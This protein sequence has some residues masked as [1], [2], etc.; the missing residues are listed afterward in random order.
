M[1]SAYIWKIGVSIIIRNIGNKAYWNFYIFYKNLETSKVSRDNN[2]FFFN[3]NKF[4]YIINDYS[5]FNSPYMCRTYS[6]IIL[7]ACETRSQCL[8]RST[9]SA[10]EAI[11]LALHSVLHALYRRSTARRTRM[12]NTIWNI[13]SVCFSRSA[14]SATEAISFAL[15][16]VS[17][18]FKR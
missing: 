2:N 4:Y 18:A 11:S 12:L 17:H 16:S 6:F 14:E 8:S 10:T 7:R 13:F 9:E 15:H 5:N 1:R 3:F